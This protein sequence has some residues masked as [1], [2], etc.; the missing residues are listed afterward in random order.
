M[1]DKSHVTNARERVFDK[2]NDGNKIHTM[3]D[4]NLKS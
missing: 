3:S 4:I 2:R 1:F